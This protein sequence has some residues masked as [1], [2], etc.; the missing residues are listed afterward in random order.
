[1]GLDTV[2]LAAQMIFDGNRRLDIY[3]VIYPIG[4]TLLG[5]LRLS[6]RSTM[7]DRPRTRG[8]R[9]GRPRRPAGVVG[10]TAAPGKKLPAENG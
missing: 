1:M 5:F 9:R 4:H 8:R 6:R 2:F 7:E 10:P 3:R